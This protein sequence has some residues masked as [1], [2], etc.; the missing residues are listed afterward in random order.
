MITICFDLG[1]TRSKAAVFREDV[2]MEEAGL[3]DD[4]LSS[5]AM[6]L[7]K[8]KPAKTIL[9]SVV[10]HH[11]DLEG[12]L[13]SRSVFHLLSHKSKLNFNIGVDKPETVGQDRLSLSAA[14][15]HSFPGRNNLVISM[16]SCITYNFISKE[17]IFLGG[18]IS[19]GM[20]MRFRAM[21]VFTARLP[22]VSADPSIINWAVPLV[23]Y[24]TVSNMQSGVIHGMR[25]EIDGFID[26][27]RER[28]EGLHCIL[29]G[30]HAAYF[31][32]QLKNR[33]F[34]DNNFLFKGLY[35]LSEINNKFS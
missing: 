4:E 1:N 24:N 34:A 10:D 21:Q 13:S 20:N 9:S 12:L 3:G 28:Y 22:E 6:L 25:G 30:G 14:A 2:L 11:A 32:G 23:G 7:E 18:A 8:F 19:P 35:V 31:A 27:Y 17:H 16:G 5:A 29:T 33:I 26:A 15:V